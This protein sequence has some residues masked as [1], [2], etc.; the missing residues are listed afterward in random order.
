MN[1]RSNRSGS[2]TS[3]PFKDIMTSDRQTDRPGRKDRTLPI[4]IIN[5]TI[6]QKIWLSQRYNAIAAAGIKKLQ[7][8]GVNILFDVMT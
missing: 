3:C 7:A 1:N 5:S 2:V 8:Q 4:I 6:E